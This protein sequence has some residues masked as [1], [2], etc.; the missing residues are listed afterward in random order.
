MKLC[1]DIEQNP[2]PEISY[3]NFSKLSDKNKQNLRI[4]HMNFQDVSK[5]HTQLKSFV[6]D[7]GPNAI[8]GISESWLTPSD[9][10]VFWNV[11]SNTHELFRSDRS[12]ANSKKGGGVMLLR[13]YNCSNAT[14]MFNLFVYMLASVV[15]KHAPVKKYLRKRTPKLL[16][17]SWYDSEC[18]TLTQ[19]RQAAYYEYC[20]NTSAQTWSTYSKLRNQLS[21]VLKEK[22]E[23]FAWSCFSSLCTAKERW[24]FINSA[25]GQNKKSVNLA[26]VR[27][28]FGKMIVDDKEMADRFNLIFSNLG[29]CFGNINDEIPSFLPGD[30]SFSSSPITVKD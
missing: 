30:S 26:A 4:V 23:K 3:D 16:K 13:I 22:Q 17:E 8:V 7:M 2:G 9:D 5:K 14:D 10:M 6:N 21:K 12:S 15:E 1:G 19:A 27:N 25:R 11:A 18:K 28:S 20:N 24:N 29:Q